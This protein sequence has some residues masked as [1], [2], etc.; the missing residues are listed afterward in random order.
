MNSFYLKFVYILRLISM[1]AAYDIK[2][3][4]PYYKASNNQSKYHLFGCINQ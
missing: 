1:K 4:I 3:Y 2:I